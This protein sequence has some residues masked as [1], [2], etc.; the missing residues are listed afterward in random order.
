MKHLPSKYNIAE[1]RKIQY[2]TLK[3]N[4]S[5]FKKHML[6]S[7]TFFQHIPSSDQAGSDRYADRRPSFSGW[8][9]LDHVA[10]QMNLIG[11]TDKNKI[12]KKLHSVFW[13]LAT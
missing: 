2:K 13:R 12:S 7:I 1:Y 11:Y 3:N 6:D 8:T 4:L 10:E 5:T 9:T